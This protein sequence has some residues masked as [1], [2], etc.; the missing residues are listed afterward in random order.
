M[1]VSADRAKVISIIEKMIKPEE[2][3]SWLDDLFYSGDGDEMIENIREIAKS[4]STGMNW[5]YDLGPVIP[6]QQATSFLVNSCG[7]N[8]F[9]SKTLRSFFIERSASVIPN[10]DFLIFL[11]EYSINDFEDLKHIFVDEYSPR[12]K[13]CKSFLDLLG[14]PNSYSVKNPNIKKKPLITTRTIEKLP[15]MLDY[16]VFVKEKTKQK[17]LQN[18]GRAFVVM[19]TGSGK[20]RTVTQ[21]FIELISDGSIQ[22]NGVLWI[23]ET[24][25]LLE[26]ATE[27]IVKVAERISSIPLKIWRY[28]EGNDCEFTIIDDIPLV[29]GITVCGKDQLGDRFESL[30][31]IATSIIDNSSLIIIDESHR[32][33]NFIY[34]LNSYLKR[35]SL[36]TTMIG[37]SATPFRRDAREDII[38]AEVFPSNS[39]TPIGDGDLDSER[40]VDTMVEQEILAKRVDVSLDSLDIYNVPN[41]DE[42]QQK[43]TVEII[44]KL[45]E[46]GHESILVFTPNI[47]WAELSNLMLGLRNPNVKTDYLHGGTPSLVRKMIIQDFRKRKLDVLFNCEILTTGFDA[48]L[49]DAVVIV[50][51]AMEQTDPLFIQMVGR[52]LRGRKFNS[53]VKQTCSIVHQR[54]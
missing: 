41:D 53:D 10:D 43:C 27:T 14:I 24:K 34:K 44:E 51:P 37:I 12:S 30:D 15:P 8:L 31:T 16:Q 52:G 50:R 54:W 45:L 47:K 20:T 19:P 5:E 25:E 39:I 9:N 11:N 40:L 26:Q 35:K 46:T 42:S 4:I 7:N 23:A 22:Q 13:P 2:F 18:Q 21:S 6:P 33:I 17:I 3:E 29:E 36:N 38:L 49:I 28:W 32:N 1:T 48:P